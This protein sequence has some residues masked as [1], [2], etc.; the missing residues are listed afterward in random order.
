VAAHLQPVD[1]ALQTWLLAHLR[2]LVHEVAAVDRAAVQFLED[3]LVARAVLALRPSEPRPGTSPRNALL[4][5]HDEEPD[6]RPSASRGCRRSTD[7]EA[8]FDHADARRTC[9]QKRRGAG[10]QGLRP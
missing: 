6:H 9:R 5:G 3:A 7:G 1:L 4:G 10:G 2:V 8:A